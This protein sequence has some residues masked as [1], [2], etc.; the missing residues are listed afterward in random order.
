VDRALSG[1]ATLAVAPACVEH[2]RYQW[3]PLPSAVT[4]TSRL[5]IMYYAQYRM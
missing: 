5:E 2:Y 4:V 1:Y 3:T